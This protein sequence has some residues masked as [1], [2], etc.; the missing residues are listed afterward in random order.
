MPLARHL[1]LFA[2]LL[3][4]L[5]ALAS[6]AEEATAPERDFEYVEML[7]AFVVNIGDSGRIAFLK[8]EVSLR[9]SAQAAALVRHH[10]PALRHEMIMLLGRESPE[11][12]ASPERRE[13]VRAEALQSLRHVLAEAGPAPDSGEEDADDEAHATPGK[14]HAGDGIQDLMFTS[15]I[16]QR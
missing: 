8:A 4:P 5:G 11:S 15:F 13:V 2:L 14:D 3:A 9:V 1:F 7:P 6:S 16:T 10:M 12:L